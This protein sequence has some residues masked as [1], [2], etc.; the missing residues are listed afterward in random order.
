MRLLS[1][2]LAVLM[3]GAVEAATCDPLQSID[4]T[5][6]VHYVSDSSLSFA[7][8]VFWIDTSLTNAEMQSDLAGAEER[9]V[10]AGINVEFVADTLVAH[11]VPDA[12]A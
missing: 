2:F 11:R 12:A 6:K 10:N 8:N 5:I 4:L 1:L 3:S 7:G 9:L